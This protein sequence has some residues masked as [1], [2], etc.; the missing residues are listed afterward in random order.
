[1]FEWDVV[2][3]G[4]GPAGMTAGLYLGQANRRVVLLDKEILSGY[5]KNI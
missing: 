4:G 1:M 2:I 5:I 3:I